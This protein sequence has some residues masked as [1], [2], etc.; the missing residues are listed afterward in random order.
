MKNREKRPYTQGH[1]VNP[2]SPYALILLYFL[3]RLGLNEKTLI[4]LRLLF[5]NHFTNFYLE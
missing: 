5:K 4:T 3:N 2:Y 1:F